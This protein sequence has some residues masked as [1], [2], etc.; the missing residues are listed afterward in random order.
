MLFKFPDCEVAAHT[1][2]ALADRLAEVEA[3][4]DDLAAVVDAVEIEH[5]ITDNG[6]LWR[7]WSDKAR[8]F[9]DK[10]KDYRSRAEAAEARNEELSNC[11]AVLEAKLAQGIVVEY[12]DGS[13][14]CLSAFA[15]GA[16][17]GGAWSHL[18]LMKEEQ[19]G[20]ASYRHYTADGDWCSSLVF[21]DPAELKGEKDE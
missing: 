4:R 10:C 11:I 16:S 9:A 19:D 20:S 3:E 21:S 8:E 1:I 12:E 17:E 18:T 2:C 15:G 6:N 14:I 7:F 5:R 13:R